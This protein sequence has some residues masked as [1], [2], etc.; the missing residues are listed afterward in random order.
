M[1]FT[2]EKTGERISAQDTKFTSPDQFENDKKIGVRAHTTAA[3]LRN[4]D[5]VEVTGA[6]IPG[7]NHNTGAHNDVVRGYPK[8]GRIP[9]VS[10]TTSNEEAGMECSGT[11]EFNGVLIKKTRS[12]SIPDDGNWFY[13]WTELASAPPLPDVAKIEPIKAKL[14]Q[15][16]TE[17]PTLKKMG[18]E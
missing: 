9:S 6:I 3:S 10:G 17:E 4:S 11:T 15:T 8:N 18:N 13:R 16:K 1:D 7:D 2:D 5:M 14:I 12:V